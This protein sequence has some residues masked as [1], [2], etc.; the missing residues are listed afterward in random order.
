[1]NPT[2]GI[3]K[4]KPSP[5]K[6]PKKSDSKKGQGEKKD[7]KDDSEGF[8]LHI[9]IPPVPPEYGPQYTS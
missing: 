3:S 2:G 5:S 7:S 4:G 1:M 6:A 8:R 9:D